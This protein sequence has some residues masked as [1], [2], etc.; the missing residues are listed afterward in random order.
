MNQHCLV[1]S[2]VKHVLSPNFPEVLAHELEGKFPN[3][4]LML[5]L[6]V[7]YPNFW[8]DNPNDVEDMLNDW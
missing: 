3:H 1:T 2:D 8:I 5:A 7:V 4:E 6:G